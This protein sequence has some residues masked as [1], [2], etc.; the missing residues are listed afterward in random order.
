MMNWLIGGGI[1]TVVLI[2]VVIIILW[3]SGVFSKEGIDVR[4]RAV[5][6]VNSYDTQSN[7]LGRGWTTR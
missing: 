1:G 6:I 2:V 5:R 7:V 3:A 4:G